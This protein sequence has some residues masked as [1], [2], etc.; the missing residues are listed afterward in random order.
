MLSPVA[1]LMPLRASRRRS[2]K[3][4][5]PTKMCIRDRKYVELYVG[6]RVTYD[7]NDGSGDTLTDSHP[8]YVTGSTV[9]VLGN[10][11]TPHAGYHLSLIHI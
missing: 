8:P 6:Y 5:K 3:D 4:A 11:F 10:T 7:A 1:G 9:T 2:S